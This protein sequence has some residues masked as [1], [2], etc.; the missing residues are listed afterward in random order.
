MDTKYQHTTRHY[1]VF[2]EEER[3][4]ECNELSVQEA[5]TSAVRESVYQSLVVKSF[6]TIIIVNILY[7]DNVQ[8]P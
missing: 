6:L 5:C 1:G 2:E 8:L 7:V 3:C 4:N